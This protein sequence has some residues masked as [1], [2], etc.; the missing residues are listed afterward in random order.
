MAHQ[1]VEFF[2]E[3][4]LDI[5]ETP[6]EPQPTKPQPKKAAEVNE[7]PVIE[8]K[9]VELDE[10][11]IDFY[12]RESIDRKRV[13][14]IAEM[15][16]HG[17]I[18]D[19]IL[20]AEEKGKYF[21]IDG[22][23]RITAREKNGGKQIDA[24]ILELKKEL[25]A[26]YSIRY[27][28]GKSLQ[29]KGKELKDAI[30]KAHLDSK[31]PPAKIAEIVNA[32]EDWVNKI[33]RKK[34]DKDKREKASTCYNLREKGISFGKISKITGVPKSTAERYVKE[35]QERREAVKKKELEREEKAALAKKRA[36]ERAYKKAENFERENE[37]CVKVEDGDSLVDGLDEF[38]SAFTSP[39]QIIDF[40]DGEEYK[41]MLE[42]IDDPSLDTLPPD[43]LEFEE[44]QPSEYEEFSPYEK[45][46]KL[47]IAF[48]KFFKKINK[49]ERSTLYILDH[50]SKNT[51]IV[52][53]A[54]E[55]DCPKEWVR[56]TAVALL[57]FYHYEEI[58][59]DE[60]SVALS[61]NPERVTFVKFLYDSY[62]AAIP[63]RETLFLWLE[64][65]MP[66]Y[67]DKRYLQITRREKLY[68]YCKR[69]GRPVPWQIDKE[70]EFYDI[71]PEVADNT[72][73]MFKYLLNLQTEIKHLK[74]NKLQSQVLLEKFNRLTIMVNQIVAELSEHAHRDDE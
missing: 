26:A 32:S 22:R 56:N 50:V 14:L 62:K 41:E 74:L 64:N 68:W 72:E 19:P 17:T 23:H 10:I 27:N 44:L 20:L 6:P 25:W 29:L 63:E 18:F 66:K 58:D 39:S 9:L 34:R 60:V 8:R 11:E 53:I 69:E 61:M 15:M 54:A 57:Y 71:P 1:A 48:E 35:E 45:T 47:I 3:I 70:V 2:P 37:N 13:D 59:V 42:G 33:L 55:L 28:S 21:L 65:N 73:K 49:N 30:W 40:E 43:Q 46:S 67:R 36:E 38:T 51:P 24:Q 7:P 52:D 5:S 12:P 16:E 31:L 4:D